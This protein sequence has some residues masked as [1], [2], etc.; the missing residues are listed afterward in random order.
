MQV[1]NGTAILQFDDVSTGNA[2]SGALVTVRD[3]NIVSGTGSLASIF[4]LTDTPILNPL[5]ADAQ[6]NYS[7]KA[8]DGLYDI[9]IREG[10]AN[11]VIIPGVSFSEDVAFF[12]TLAALAASFLSSGKN[13]RT[14]ACL[15][16]GDG[17]G[18]SY[19]VFTSA[20]YATQYPGQ[21]VD[22]FGGAVT[23]ANNN[24]VVMQ[25]V[26]NIISYAQFSVDLTGVAVAD[27]ML[28]ACHQFADDNQY[29]VVNKSGTVYWQTREI[30]LNDPRDIDLTGTTVRMDVNSGTTA[31][32][33]SQ[34]IMFTVN[35][36]ADPIALVSGDITLLNTTHSDFFKKLSHRLPNDIFGEYNGCL[37]KIIGT[38]LDVNRGGNALS[39]FNKQE[40]VTLGRRGQTEQPIYKGYEGTISSVTVYPREVSQFEF[41]CPNLALD[42][43]ASFTFLR[44]ER[45]NVKVSGLVI[46]EG[47]AWPSSVREVVQA[48]NCA[49][50]VI[51][52]WDCLAMPLGTTSAGGIYCFT[53]SHIV[54]MQA[55]RLRGNTGWGFTGCNFLKNITFDNNSINRID[56]HWGAYDITVTNNRLINWGCL[57]A[58]GGTFTARD[59]EYHI[60]GSLDSPVG[61]SI[62][63]SFLE[64]RPDYGAEWDGDIIIDGL[65]YIIDPAYIDGIGTSEFDIVKMIPSPTNADF[66]RAMYHGRNVV[67]KNVFLRMDGAQQDDTADTTLSFNALN[68][69]VTN[70]AAQDQYY[71]HSILID[72]ISS[73]HQANKVKI[74]AYIPPNYMA[75]STRALYVADD[76]T[77][78]DYNQLITIKNINAGRDNVTGGGADRGLVRF[79]LDWSLA[80]LGTYPAYLTDTQ[81]IRPLINIHDC[82]SVELG[83][84]VVGNVK[85]Y[86]SEVRKLQTR[87]YPTAAPFGPSSSQIIIDCFNSNLRLTSS[88]SGSDSWE[89][90]DETSV[91]NCGFDNLIKRAGT[92]NATGSASS[93]KGKGNRKIASTTV[94][95]SSTPMLFDGE[96]AYLEGTGTPT[97]V[98][99]PSF[100]GQ[101]YKDTSEDT[102]FY[103]STGITSADW[104]QDLHTGDFGLG[105]TGTNSPVIADLADPDTPTGIYSTTSSSFDDNGNG[106]TPNPEGFTVNSVI[107]SHDTLRT[108]QTLH[109]NNNNTY[110]RRHNGTDWTTWYRA[111]TNFD[112]GEDVVSSQITYNN[113]ATQTFTREAVNTYINRWSGGAPTYTFDE[114]TYLAGDKVYITRLWESTGEITI[115]TD[116]GVIYLPDATSSAT[117]TLDVVG[118]IC[119]EKIDLNN[120]IAR[121]G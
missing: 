78:G 32:T 101:V 62:V 13:V 10:E 119:L 107:V 39:F 19:K 43:V 90:P 67:I 104:I 6:G 93:F 37:V 18:S 96:D 84:A 12:P 76:I 71:P 48:L 111:I 97:G 66:G 1:Y 57:L 2:D 4:D 35:A 27:D 100:I 36:T 55:Q 23:L 41:K 65:T 7:F 103:T 108:Y 29:S 117:Q 82:H 8:V 77:N 80:T 52:D 45:S 56:C 99:T 5:T 74:T 94:W 120:W 26:N 95:T 88:K 53:G 79:N 34:P 70:V 109:T 11:E 116:E 91:Y 60:T 59:N 25:P 14:E 61:E 54:D 51:E 81:A 72:N 113:A 64:V 40:A 49:K 63:K 21:S 16:A 31:L 17:G 87:T 98:V 33:Y 115:V 118:T 89:L 110:Q 58:G 42:G 102:G 3:Y 20:E 92:Y 50:L 38:E 114:S 86:N 28:A 69:G 68:F 24:I 106:A 85:V 112:V 9:I 30:E 47:D 105:G 73:T 121:V 83:L 15:S 22:E 46:T 44:I 75:P